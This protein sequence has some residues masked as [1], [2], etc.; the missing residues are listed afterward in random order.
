MLGQQ[1]HLRQ[2]AASACLRSCK[3]LANA[4]APPTPPTPSAQ[5]AEAEA[6]RQRMQSRIMRP[7]SKSFSLKP[8]GSSADIMVSGVGWASIWLAVLCMQCSARGAC[9]PALSVTPTKPPWVTL[10]ISLLLASPLPTARSPPALA[11]HS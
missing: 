4:V 7:G 1:V 11:K 2:C 5:A 10:P 3:T 8:G 6:A 9:W